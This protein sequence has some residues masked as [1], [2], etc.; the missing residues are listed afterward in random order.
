MYS[1][2]KLYTKLSSSNFHPQTA[3][4]FTAELSASSPVCKGEQK[5]GFC[6]LCCVPLP[7]PSLSSRLQGCPAPQCPPEQR[8]SHCTIGPGTGAKE[9]PALAWLAESSFFPLVFPLNTE[10]WLSISISIYFLSFLQRELRGGRAALGFCALLAH[11]CAAEVAGVT[12]TC[13]ACP[14]AQLCGHRPFPPVSELNLMPI[15]MEGLSSAAGSGWILPRLPHGTCPLPF[16]IPPYSC[17][18][19]GAPGM[20][21]EKPRRSLWNEACPIAVAVRDTAAAR[22]LCEVQEL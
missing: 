18:A 19:S 3:K 17:R 5:C 20:S 10:S 14:G 13:P 15:S 7:Q 1:K 8:Y 12:R 2:K 22:T 4:C 6:L 16:L 21:L 9:S 11:P